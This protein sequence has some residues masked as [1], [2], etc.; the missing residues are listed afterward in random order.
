M[1]LVVQ[2]LQD[3]VLAAVP[4]PQAIQEV[5][6]VVEQAAATLLGPVAMEMPGVEETAQWQPTAG[7][8]RWEQ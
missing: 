1:D 4:P 3:Q 8:V 7:P 5:W 2:V 6:V